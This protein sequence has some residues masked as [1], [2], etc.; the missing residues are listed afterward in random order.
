MSKNRGMGEI[1]LTKQENKEMKGAK[2]DFTVK[3]VFVSKIIKW[4]QIFLRNNIL[5]VTILLFHCLLVQKNYQNEISSDDN[6]DVITFKCTYI[7]DISR[8]AWHMNS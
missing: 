8:F 2:R 3:I 4:E 5:L 1:C 6:Q 7:L